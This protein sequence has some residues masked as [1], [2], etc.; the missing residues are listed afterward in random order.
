MGERFD[1]AIVGAGL[2]GSALAYHLTRDPPLRV[3]ALDLAPDASRPSG[4]QTSAGIVSV[5]G[6]DPWDLAVVRESANEYRTI[7]EAEGAEPLR[8]NGGLRLART[9]AGTR[10][11]ERCQRVLAREGLET[12]WLSEGQARDLLPC[13]SSDDLGRGLY[14]PEDAVVSPLSLRAAYAR[15]AARAGAV[16]R[17]GASPPRI[18]GVADGAA[19]ATGVSSRNSPSATP[20]IL[21]GLAPE[22]RT[23]PA[24][25]AA[26]A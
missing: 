22:R 10:W 18:E 8:R 7:A 11:L 6:W 5:Q 20:S 12:R 19:A 23:A 13:A 24:R 14:T 17:S 4:T 21:G 2:F 16:L 3:L 15:A 1:V 26:R 25:A 9:P